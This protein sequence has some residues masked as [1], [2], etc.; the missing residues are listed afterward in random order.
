M[1]ATDYGPYR[2][3]TD[4]EAPFV[5]GPRATPPRI[6][7]SCFPQARSSRSIIILLY[8]IL[9]ILAFG[10]HLIGVPA[11]RIFEDIICHHYYEDGKS[12]GYKRLGDID[13]EM[14]KGEEIQNQL[15]ILLAGS[16]FLGAIPG[17]I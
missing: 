7:K 1:A 14:C 8:C 17:R 16:H 4:E 10:G 6:R 11:L 3:S 15:N 9:F 12:E 2:D 5:P 13:E